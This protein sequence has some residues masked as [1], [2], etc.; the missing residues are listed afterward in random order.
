MRW[1]EHL[2]IHTRTESAAAQLLSSMRPRDTVL[3]TKAAL[4][5]SILSAKGLLCMG[6][7]PA[8][9]HAL[10][11]QN[12]ATPLLNNKATLN[13]K[14]I[15]TLY[16]KMSCYN[17][18]L[19]LAQHCFQHWLLNTGYIHTHATHDHSDISLAQ[20]PHT[21]AHMRIGRDRICRE[22]SEKANG[23]VRKTNTSRK[24]YQIELVM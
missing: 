3:S 15:A 12:A 23:I 18:L 5:R 13:I 6:R 8:N 22:T 4:W 7:L 24:R 20:K 11:L 17:I 19:H 2:K 9:K 14:G 16:T 1:F 21:R 10:S